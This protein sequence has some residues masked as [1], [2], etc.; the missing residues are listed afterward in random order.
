MTYDAR[1]YRLVHRGSPGD[2][3]FY[4]RVCRDADSILVLA[5]G[6]GRMLPTLGAPGRKL[7]AV[8][9]DPELLKMA[10]DELSDDIQL[11][12]SDMVSFDAGGQ[13]QRILVPHNGLWALE[14]EEEVLECFRRVREHLVPGGLLVFD[15][16]SLDGFHG[17]MSAEETTDLDH[18]VTVDAPDGETFDV[19]ERRQWEPE[20]QRLV[21][22]YAYVPRSGGP[23]MEGTVLHHYLLRPQVEQLLGLS[24]LKVERIEGGFSG[25]PWSPEAPHL[26]VTATR[27]LSN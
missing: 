13:F 26:V 24:G 21:V 2:E 8:E 9:R 10:R 11:I 22:S 14:N 23:D 20:S 25:E 1:L 19:Y 15:T 4:E 12:E 16:A 6:W 17:A 7:A 18:V 5:C 3:T 27:P